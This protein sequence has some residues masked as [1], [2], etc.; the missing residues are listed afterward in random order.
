MV[1]IALPDLGSLAYLEAFDM[2]VSDV[3]V[4]ANR[5]NAW[6]TVPANRF[7]LVHGIYAAHSGGTA[8]TSLRVQINPAAVKDLIVVGPAGAPG[9]G[10]RHHAREW[11][12]MMPGWSIVFTAA[13]GDA[14]SDYEYGCIA[15]EFFGR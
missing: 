5:V 9:V 15:L 3:N 2:N 10:V 11:Y 6:Y 4:G 8:P 12:A 1:Q 7:A 13:G 14:T